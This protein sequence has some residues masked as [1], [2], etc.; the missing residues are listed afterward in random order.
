EC[1]GV[2]APR[3][4]DDLFRAGDADALSHALYSAHQR[5]KT[6]RGLDEAELGR[7][8][9]NDE[10]AGQRELEAAA[11]G[12]TVDAGDDRQRMP[13][14]RPQKADGFKILLEPLAATLEQR[15]VGPRGK[16]P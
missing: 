4:H 6:E 9:R 12:D 16:M 13:F 11:E 10:I 2:E 15:E 14:D 8:C 3:Q 7:R 5:M 1:G